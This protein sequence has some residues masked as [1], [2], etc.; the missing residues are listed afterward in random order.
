MIRPA[1]RVLLSLAL[2]AALAA[3]SAT[4]TPGPGRA[5]SSAEPATGLSAEVTRLLARTNSL[6]ATADDESAA[7]GG[8]LATANGL[9]LRA[10]VAAVPFH[11]QTEHHCGPAAL[12]MVLGWSGVPAEPEDLASQVVTPGREGTLAHDLVAAARRADR[13][14]VPI[15]GVEPLLAELAAGHP[16]LVLQN[17]ALDWYAQWHYAVAIGY[18]LEEGT[19]T[20]HSGEEA[21]RVMP[22]MTF[23]RTWERADSWGLAVLP[24]DQLPVMVDESTVLEAAVGLEQAG[25]YDSAVAAYGAALERWPDS[26]PALIGLGNARLAAG[27]LARAEA[28]FRTAVSFHPD[29]AAAWNNLAHVLAEQGEFGEALAAAKRAVDLGGTGATVYQATLDEIQQAI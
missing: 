14:A 2:L 9:P 25:Q 18:D 22:L 16:V 20:L 15:Q 4:Q 12:A 5:A 7:A 10:Q 19:V 3:C 6:S 1:T 21:N 29:Q 24:A 23:A 13:L 27:H 11:A 28:A 26:F 17:L 8:G